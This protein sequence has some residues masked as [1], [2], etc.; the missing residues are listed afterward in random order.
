MH[1]SWKR[2]A[3]ATIAVPLLAA[4]SAYGVYQYLAPESGHWPAIS[5]AIGFELLYL[6][7]NLLVLHTP[8]LRA[9]G[10]RVALAAVITAVTFNT[11]AHYRIKVEAG[12]E[13]AALDWLALALSLLTSLPLA[14]LA[15]AVSVL[16][17]RLSET[18]HA[19]RTAH[20]EAAPPPHAPHTPVAMRMAVVPESALLGLKER[21]SASAER[22]AIYPC[23]RCGSPISQQQAAAA[24]RWGNRWRGCEQC[25]QPQPET[26][27]F[28]A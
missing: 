5:A 24:R 18:E 19:Q 2:T 21:S 4:P 3:L 27:P 12:L 7:V 16:L 23:P 25:Q 20:T 15:Y 11:L 22:Y 9:Y 26:H 10:R 6:G 13:G 28:T 17:H 14:G 8:E 1:N